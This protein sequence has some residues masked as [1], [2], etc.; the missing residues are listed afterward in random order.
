MSDRNKEFDKGF[1]GLNKLIEQAGIQNKYH[2]I[3]LPESKSISSLQK[4][5]D[6]IQQQTSFAD[7]YNSLNMTRLQQQLLDSPMVKGV[8][9]SAI[10][11]GMEKTIEATKFTAMKSMLDLHELDAAWKNLI[12]SDSIISNKLSQLNTKTLATHSVW[13]V[14]VTSLATKLS[15]QNIF[16]ARPD[17]A[18]NLFEASKA[19]TDFVSSTTIKL[20]QTSNK[21][22]LKALSASLFLTNKQYLSTTE[23]L[24]D[25]TTD[26]DDV[27]EDVSEPKKLNLFDVQQEEL[28]TSAR[29]AE[30]DEQELIEQSSTNKLFGKVMIVL[31][32]ISKCN[33][34]CKLSGRPEIF[35]PTT[36]MLEAFSQMPMLVATDKLSLGSVVDY[37]Y[38]L[39]YEGAGTD[40]LRFLTSNQ[41]VLH[42]SQC[43][44]VWCVKN[45]RNKWL[46]HN[47]DRGQQSQIDKSW[48]ELSHKFNW[49]GLQHLP[50]NQKHFF[51]LHYR[52]L[53][54]A[55]KFLTQI[56]LELSRRK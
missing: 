28:I 11:A 5:I 26:I 2:K 52:L 47:P 3:V 18:K 32:L 8:N 6:L 50:F 29:A 22:V 23:T 12:D 44:F 10:L 9:F 15:S 30:V 33:E 43:D 4:T 45:L 19:Y 13:G 37:L 31:G 54:E 49:L 14:G 24:L 17:L 25:F 56:L 16:E 35:K 7:V 51:D 48:K 38:F 46:R 34:A 53:L 40:K 55:E 27:N 20:E 1:I 36:R 42:E 39:F 41:G 21:D